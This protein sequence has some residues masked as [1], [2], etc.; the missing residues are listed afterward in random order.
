MLAS[1]LAPLAPLHPP[2]I[3]ELRKKS[4]WEYLAKRERDKLEDLEAEIVDEEHLFSELELTAAERRELEYKR[5]V[6]D[7]AKDYKR[8]GEQEKLEKSSRYY[9]PEESRGKVP[10]AGSEEELWEGTQR[11]GHS[12]RESMAGEH[13][14]GAVARYLLWGGSH[15]K[16]PI[17]G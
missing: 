12:L 4:R 9:M 1:Q 5:R 3:P 14:G 8:A 16:G 13:S 17:L 7:L 10:T 15:H 6:R 2:Q 11:G